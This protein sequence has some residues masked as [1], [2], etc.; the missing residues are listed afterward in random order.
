V[1]RVTKPFKVAFSPH[2]ATNYASGHLAPGDLLRY[3]ET[4]SYEQGCVN[5]TQVAE[6]FVVL[7]GSLAGHC[8]RTWGCW[9]PDRLC[10]EPVS[11]NDGQAS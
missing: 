11:G 9:E 1:W 6:R 8:V 7:S 5:E 2:R 10:I 4:S 3:E